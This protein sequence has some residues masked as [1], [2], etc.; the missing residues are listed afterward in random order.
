[1][2]GVMLGLVMAALMLMMSPVESQEEP[3]A[4]LRAEREMAEAR[5]AARLAALLEDRDTLQAALEQARQAHA[6]AQERVTPLLEQ[7]QA[8]EAWRE[9][10]DERQA[11]QGGDLAEVLETLA[12]HSGELRDDLAESWLTLG[13]SELPP[14][15]DDIEVLRPEHLETLGDA[16]LALTAETGRVVAFEAP[17]AAVDGQ[18]AERE[19]VRV[20]DLGVFAD[21]A[22]LERGA[23]EGVLSTAARTPDKVS[24]LLRDFQA[25]ENE[26]LV[27]DPSGG[28]VIDALSRQPSLVE[29][30]HQGGAVGYV[31]VGLGIIGLLVAL[32]QYAYLL[33]VSV[34]IR[35]QLRDL[36]QLRKDNPL[37]RVLLRFQA[38]ADDSV[39]EALEARLDEAVLAELPRLER[40][41]PLVKLL[42]AV[43]PLLGLLGT[44]TGM[45][46]TFQA[47]TVFG[48]GDPQLM[49][50]GISQALVTTVLGLITAVP[51]LF[52]Q[53]ALA[54][55]SRHLAGVVE[56][57]ASAALA[58]QL[59]HRQ[60]VSHPAGRLHRAA[61]LA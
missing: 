27:L 20:G 6:E 3:L 50:G 23:E 56:G 21:G 48:T 54:G 55:R 39:P 2:S 7:R 42:A 44:V 18:V 49:A 43:A 28:Q 45:I 33:R 41:Q 25:G 29:R 16:L 5:D 4:S 59:E 47:I 19:V 58:E 35:R 9:E 52:A 53:T 10:L 51:L 40:G 15:L 13:G 17:V 60:P 57:Q 22:L 11:E 36:D 1:M 30:F 32:L 37:G 31:V 12:Q 46:V 8:Q 24:T 14:R 34:A 61:T 38:L 26:R